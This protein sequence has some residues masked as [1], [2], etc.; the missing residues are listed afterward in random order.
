MKYGKT[1]L[2]LTAAL[3]ALLGLGCQG[4]Q[5]NSNPTMSHGEVF[6][7][8]DDSRSYAQFAEAQA[9]NGARADA[10][11]YSAHFDGSVLNT[12]GMAKLRRMVEAQDAEMLTVYLDI[13]DD[14]NAAGR[15]ADVTKYLNTLG[16]PAGQFALAS[17]P[18][19]ANHSPSIDNQ[20]A[21]A[22]LN[23]AGAPGGGSG[24]G[25]SGGSSGAAPSAPSH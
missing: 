12:L 20:T 4:Q 9:I 7:P 6:P 18:N 5:T 15:H 17:G 22:E 23:A 10:T 14:A 3:A 19:P 21:E 2:L 24:G 16:V 13:P 8:E 11:L 25:S 1:T